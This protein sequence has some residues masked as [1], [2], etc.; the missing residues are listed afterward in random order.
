MRDPARDGVREL[1]WGFLGAL[2]AE[3][4]AVSPARTE[5]FFRALAVSAPRDAVALYWRARL[6]L[7]DDVGLIPAFDAVFGSWM[8][9]EEPAD[10]AGH[11]STGVPAPRGQDTGEPPVDEAVLGG[12]ARAGADT[13]TRTRAFGATGDRARLLRALEA[14]WPRALPTTRSRRRR[15]SRSRGTLALRA[16]A[17]LA[18]RTGGEIVYLRR[19]VRPPRN[20][21]VL[22]LVDVSGS[23]KQHTPDLLRLAHTAVRA[24]GRAEVFTFGTRLTR[25][26][27]ALAHPDTGRS[28]AAVA[29]AVSDVDGGTAIGGALDE[30]VANPRFLSLARGAVV[31]VVSDGLE[32]GD[33]DLMLRRA[34]RLSLLGHRLLWWS[35]LAC[36][37][38]Y[39]PVT[40]GIAG[41][42]PWLDHLGGVGDLPTALAELR[43]LPGVRARPRREALR[44]W[45][46]AHPG[47]Y[48]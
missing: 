10:P 18:R 41:V 40:R 12:G 39:R 1:L 19:E 13:V 27:T 23:V 35:P 15:L 45:R 43:H 30:F 33:C 24:E 26:T 29:H 14:E 8:L 25:V 3:G 22:L 2:R 47:R 37:P 38:G 34:R 9:R 11:G 16:T 21:P 17:R 36:S 7:V 31:I 4:L 6:T 48:R 44:D 46:P 5:D 28:L 42:L 32:R 20:R